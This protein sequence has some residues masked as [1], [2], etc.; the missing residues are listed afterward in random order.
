MEGFEWIGDESG[1]GVDGSI[2]RGAMSGVFEIEF[3]FQEIEGSFGE[4]FFLGNP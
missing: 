2:E 1:E 4:G 3:I